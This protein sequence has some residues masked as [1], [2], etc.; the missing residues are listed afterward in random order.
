[1][2]RPADEPAQPAGCSG[3]HRRIK[4]SVDSLFE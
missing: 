2:V 1:V 4:V 3:E